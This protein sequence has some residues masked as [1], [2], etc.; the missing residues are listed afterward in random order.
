MGGQKILIVEDEASLVE[1]LSYN[2]LREG[3]EVVLAH[4]ALVEKFRADL[5]RLR[6]RLQTAGLRLVIDVPI[7]RAGLLVAAR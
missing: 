3:Y 6:G 7:D 2:L 1:V 5:A 4:D